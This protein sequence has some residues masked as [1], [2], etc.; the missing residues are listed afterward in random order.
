MKEGR[1]HYMK[2]PF[3]PF[4]PSAQCHERARVLLRRW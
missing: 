1:K 4:L 2:G 3:I